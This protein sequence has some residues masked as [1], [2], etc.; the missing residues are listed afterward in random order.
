MIE[1]TLFITIPS[2]DRMSIGIRNK[3]MPPGKRDNAW[4]DDQSGML[5]FTLTDF[6]EYGMPAWWTN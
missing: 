6:V 3:E 5:I 4:N 2:T 1:V